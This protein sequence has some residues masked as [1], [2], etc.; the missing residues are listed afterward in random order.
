MHDPAMN[1]ERRAMDLAI[2][3]GGEIQTSQLLASGWSEAMI[4]YRVNTGKLERI[5]RGRF[6]V[7]DLDDVRSRLRSA[8]GALPDAVVSHQAAA[9]LHTIPFIPRQLRGCHC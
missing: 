3:Q 4:R 1:I 6:R 2:R 9:E 8:V 7:V 5:T